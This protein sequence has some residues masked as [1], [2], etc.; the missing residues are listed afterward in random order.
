M[1]VLL[2]FRIYYIYFERK[3]TYLFW[4]DNELR[5]N[6]SFFHEKETFNFEYI[7]RNFDNDNSFLFSNYILKSKKDNKV[8]DK[9]IININKNNMKVSLPNITRN[10]ECLDGVLEMPFTEKIKIPLGLS[11]EIKKPMITVYYF[12]AIENKIEDNQATVYVFN[13]QIKNGEE[14]KLVLYVRILDNNKHKFTFILPEE[15]ELITFNF[16]DSVPRRCVKHYKIFQKNNI[17]ITAKFKK[18]Y[19]EQFKDINFYYKLDEGDKK[20]FHVR[21]NQ[22]NSFF[23]RSHKIERFYYFPYKTILGNE[24]CIIN[25]NSQNKIRDEKEPIIFYSPCCVKFG[26]RNQ[27]DIIIEPGK[28]NNVNDFIDGIKI[29]GFKKEFG[30]YW[31]PNCSDFG[32]DIPQEKDLRI[33]YTNIVLAQHQIN[34]IL[35]NIRGS[36]FSKLMDRKEINQ[37]GYFLDFISWLVGNETDIKDKIKTL[38]KIFTKMGKEYYEKFSPYLLEDIPKKAKSEYNNNPEYKQGVFKL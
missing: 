18:D 6:N 30:D 19:S 14:L 2:Q 1:T 4:K 7:I 36:F 34:E 27:N 3:N 28:E 10:K 25:Y 24:P 11:G 9:P 5:L 21:I 26:Y 8:R 12:N 16:K 20:P 35:N 29:I 38:K 17:T 31:Y 13:H 23:R 37:Y 33:K 32:K 15:R 22:E